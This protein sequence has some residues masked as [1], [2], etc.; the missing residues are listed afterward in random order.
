MTYELTKFAAN[1]TKETDNHIHSILGTNAAPV[2]NK[3]KP[4][5]KETK[6]SNKEPWTDKQENDAK[7]LAMALSGMH[8]GRK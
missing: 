8:K 3:K 6:K 2:V 7:R 4:T 1:P 5:R